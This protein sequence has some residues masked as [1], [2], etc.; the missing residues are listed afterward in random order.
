MLIRSLQWR[1]VTIFISITIVLMISLSVILTESVEDLYYRNFKDSIEN[2]FLNWGINE[3]TNPTVDD[4]V[5][6][7]KYKGDAVLVFG[8]GEFKSYTVIDLLSGRIKDSSDAVFRSKGESILYNEMLL[9]ENL[10]AVMK[11]GTN[12]GTASEKKV[13]RTDDS[14]YFDYA[15]RVGGSIIYF[16]YNLDDTRSA[17]NKFNTII[18]NSLILA[19]LASL[20]IGYILSKTITV[21]I[22]NVMNRARKIAR[23]D[24]DQMLQVKSNDEIG[25]LTSSFNDMASALKRTLSE[26]SS[27]KRKIE[28]ILNYLTDGVV[29]YNLAG[30]L[31]HANPAAR[32]LL[33]SEIM[34]LDFNRFSLRFGLE[35]NIDELRFLENAEKRDS[36]IKHHDRIVRAYFAAFTDEGKRIEGFIVVL[37]DIT[38]QEKLDA[39]RREF[40]ANVS[41]ELRTPLTSIKSYTE[42]LLD[43]IL[44]DRDTSQR[45]LGVINSEAD[46]MTR[47]VKDLLQLSRLDNGRMKW[48]LEQLNAVELV[49]A[50]VEKLKLEAEGNGQTMECYVIGDIPEISADRDR[51]EQ[52]MMNILSNA[53]KY[54][55]AGGKI[56]VFIGKLFKEIYIKVSDTGIG[57]PQEDLTRIFERFYRVDKARSR[58]MG[59]TGLGL[60]IAK[61]IVEGHGGTI[62]IASELGKGTDVTIKLPIR[63]E[64]EGDGDEV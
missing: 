39:M 44:D 12:T 46:R 62:R 49:K 27:E 7:L 58:E 22:N 6:Q 42:T 51:I 14:A 48:T 9:S 30:E 5:S 37:K 18:L 45:F 29:A 26:I 10:I 20:V 40:V 31:I 4:V 52:V 55:P 56:T 28:T 36:Q 32:R 43:G 38:E 13:I 16:R 1:L 15:R 47:L 35:I 64:D 19:I 17:M 3:K 63:R 57:I 34:D 50:S 2:G 21:P 24:L 41:H 59:G 8:V 11:D 61:E 25:K 23:G 54:T 53:I 33:G 60:S